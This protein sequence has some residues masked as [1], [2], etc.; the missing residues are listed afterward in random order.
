MGE[1]KNVPLGHGPFGWGVQNLITSFCPVDHRLRN[2]IEIRSQ[3][4]LLMLLTE[5]QTVSVAK[6]LHRWSK[7]NVKSS[8]TEK[9]LENLNS[10]T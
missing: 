8:N 10:M 4:F 6:L 7:K 9:K 5:L 3:L 1:E 2:F